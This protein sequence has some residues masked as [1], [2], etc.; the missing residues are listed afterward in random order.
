[1]P[2]GMQSDRTIEKCR[3]T[4]CRSTGQ[5]DP[6][7]ITRTNSDEFVPLPY[8]NAFRSSM[9]LLLSS[10]ASWPFLSAL[11]LDIHSVILRGGKAGSFAYAFQNAQRRSFWHRRL[12]R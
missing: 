6:Y 12:P 8:S 2:E 9:N 11:A 5:S 3:K 4:F 1:M 7:G 10:A